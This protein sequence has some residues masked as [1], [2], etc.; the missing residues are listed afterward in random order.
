MKHLAQEKTGK[1]YKCETL[2]LSVKCRRMKV[3]VAKDDESVANNEEFTCS[4]WQQ[5]DEKENKYGGS[6]I[7]SRKF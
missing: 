5:V 4:V 7:S 6:K 1:N 2:D 3:I